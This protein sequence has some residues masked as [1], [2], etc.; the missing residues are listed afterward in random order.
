MAQFDLAR[1]KAKMNQPSAAS[2]KIQYK[3]FSSV[4]LIKNVEAIPTAP[5]KNVVKE[6]LVPGRGY[7]DEQINTAKPTLKEFVIGGAKAAGEIGVGISSLASTALRS[8][9]ITRPLAGDEEVT[10][11]YE[12]YVTPST[13]GEAKVMRGTDIAGFAPAAIGRISKLDDLARLSKLSKN[14]LENSTTGV[15]SKSLEFFK[16]NPEEITK[17]E[18]RVRELEDGSLFIEDGRHRIQAGLEAGIQ[19]KVV[20]VTKEHTGKA[21]TKVAE[22]G[23]KERGFISSTKAVIPEASKVAGQY[24]PRSTDEL[25]MKASN[26]IKDDPALAFTRATTESGE[27][28]VAIASELIKKYSND[29]ANAVDDLAKNDAYDKAAEVANSIATK[30]TESGRAVQAASILGRMTPEGQLRFAAREIQKFNEAN[31]TKKIKELTGE[32]A[33]EITEEMKIINSMPDGLDKAMRL[34]KLQQKVTSLIPSPL[35]KKITTVWKAGLLTGVKTSGLNLFSNFSH[36]LSEVAKDAPAAA[37]DSVAS[38][39]TGKRTKTFTLRKAFDGI[40][41]GSVKGKRYFSTGFDERNIGAKLDYSRV[42]FGKGVVGKAFQAYTDTVFKTLGA[43][44]QPFYYAALSRSLMDQALANGKNL[45]LK[46]KELRDHAYKIVENPSEEMIRYGVAD[47]T[48][49]VFQ[50]RTKLGDAAGTIQKLPGVG[51]IVLPF[52]QTPSSVAMQIIAYSPVGAIKTVFENVGKGKFDQRLFSQGLGRSIVGT[53]FLALGYKLGEKGLVSLGYPKGDEAEQE[54]QKA[55][56][57]KPNSILINGKWRSPMVLGPMG[58]IIL[59]GAHFSDALQKAGSP[60]EAAAIA[61]GGVWKSFMEQTFLT[62]VNNFAEVLQDPARYAG[63]YLPNLAA[64]TVPTIVADVARATDPKERKSQSGFTGEAFQERVQARIP[65]ARRSLEPDIDIIGRERESVGNPLEIL[66]DPTRPSP[67]TGNLVTSE[68]RRLM[69]LDY[70]VSPTKLGDRD[71]YKVLTPEQNTKLWKT[72]G[73]LTNNKLNGLFNSPQYQKAPDEQKK[74][75]VD[76]FVEK[77]QNYARAAMVAELTDGLKGAEM[78]AKLKELKE[79][80]LLTRDVYR[81]FQDIR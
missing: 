78:A 2:S 3:P 48:T 31:P 57:R 52:A 27:E 60:T 67:V 42:N 79:G 35:W 77:G 58:N 39:F 41:E 55:E 64:S 81:A 61:A 73:E 28:A 46:G 47:A 9:P 1:A 12:G 34:Q 36:A 26:L 21:S 33:K 10:K 40:K 65:G 72:S 23:T 16:N 15:R 45:G 7:S 17:G 62:G 59:M 13:A 29:A 54:L 14:S 63:S 43:T 6:F 50:N 66:A 70:R 74:K 75:I 49:A 19:Q 8:N 68:L 11:K 30:L 51:Q 4:D 80:G 32:Q 20:D 69:E 56:G 5:P 22:F 38:L 76:Q 53:A 37:I 44:D 71:G 24:I 25:S 18:V